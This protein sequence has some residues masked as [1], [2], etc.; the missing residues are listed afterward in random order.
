MTAE[1]ETPVLGR[2]RVSVVIPTLNEAANLPHV[3][4]RLPAGLHEVVLVDGHSTD[5]TV[6]VARARW[7]NRHIVA[8]ERRRGGAPPRL[9]QLHQNIT[10]GRW[11]QQT[12]RKWAWPAA[13]VAR[14]AIDSGVERHWRSPVRSA[15]GRPRHAGRPLPAT[16]HDAS[17][18]GTP[19]SG[20]FT[21]ACYFHRHPSAAALCFGGVDG[22]S[23]R[24]SEPA[25][26]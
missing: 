11:W 8:R 14:M 12:G 26:S 6:E 7:P 17:H 5:G 3:F 15:A 21:D 19:D 20:I 16:P 23:I 9:H 2:C 10:W 18:R 1:S 4:A 24:Y 25:S 22:D 13:L